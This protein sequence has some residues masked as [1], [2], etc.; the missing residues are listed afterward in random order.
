MRFVQAEK[1]VTT[2][3]PK[4]GKVEVYVEV[5]QLESLEDAEKFF[6]STDAQLAF[7][8]NAVETNAKNGARAY[9]RALDSDKTTIEEAIAKAKELAHNYSAQSGA[10]REPTVRKQAQAAKDIKALLESGQELSKEQL[11]AM[12]A[13]I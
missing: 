3:H 9:L 7:I 12:L 10:S 1:P 5:P 2:N 13:N 8:N 6:G 4:L 11:L